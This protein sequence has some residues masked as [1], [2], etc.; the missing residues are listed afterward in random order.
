MNSLDDYETTTFCNFTSS[1]AL[2]YI[3]TESLLF[4]E[5]HNNEGKTNTE[6]FS[7]LHSYLSFHNPHVYLDRHYG[8]TVKERYTMAMKAHNLVAFCEIRHHE[9]PSP[10]NHLHKSDLWIVII[11]F[12]KPALF[13][14][15]D[16]E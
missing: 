11:A 9:R 7:R 5:G 2:R 6:Y 13:D 15:A 12:M 10:L 16:T 3:A 14:V 4:I 8:E 1:E